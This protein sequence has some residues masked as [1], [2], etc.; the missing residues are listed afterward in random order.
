MNKL[1]YFLILKIIFSTKLFIKNTN[2][3]I[4]INCLYFI[5]HKNNYPYD[6]ISDDKLYGR[7]KKFGEIDFVTGLIE[8]NFAK[9]CRD[10]I[11]K[12]GKIGSEYK[13]KT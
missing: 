8:Y 2:L 10:D 5:E 9:D 11:N 4:C 1:S 13:D 12:C 3:P 6:P 7:C